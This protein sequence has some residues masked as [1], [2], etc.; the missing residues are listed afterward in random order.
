MQVWQEQLSPSSEGCGSPVFLRTTQMVS[1]PGRPSDGRTAPEP[2]PGCSAASFDASSTLLAT[3]LDDSPGTLWIWDVAAAE[4]RAVLIFYSAISFSWHPFTRELLLITCQDDASGKLSFVWDPL[5]NGPNPVVLQENPT[6][7]SQLGAKTHHCAWI[8]REA[9]PPLLFVSD[10]QNYA[11]ASISDA[12][13]L[14]SPWQQTGDSEWTGAGLS[15][16][17]D[18]AD[19]TSMSASIPEDISALD[20]TF[21]FRT[22]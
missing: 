8:R 15:A 7:N 10:A 17:R 11:L 18:L 6:P 5:S 9:D 16:G 22:A 1:P 13:Q 2:K 4:L 12:E 21:S 3:R 20:D 14:S 19:T